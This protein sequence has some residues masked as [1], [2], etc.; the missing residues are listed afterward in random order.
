MQYI[1]HIIRNLSFLHGIM[2]LGYALASLPLPL[3]RRPRGDRSP[4]G[5][6]HGSI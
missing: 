6:R 1:P 5:M 3:L 2:S 4:P